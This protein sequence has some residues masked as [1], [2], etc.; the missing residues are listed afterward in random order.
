MVPLTYEFHGN[1]TTLN[2]TLPL[3]PEVE[4]M[5]KKKNSIK[6]DSQSYHNT[7]DKQETP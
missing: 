4:V 2:S 6:K 3:S 5:N 1:E 7:S